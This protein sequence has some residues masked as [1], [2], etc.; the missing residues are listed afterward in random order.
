MDPIDIE[1]EWAEVIPILG[2]ITFS[3]F[4]GALIGLDREHAEKPAGIRTHTLMCGAACTLVMLSQ[5]LIQSFAVLEHA[6]VEGVMI[7]TDPVRVI[8]AIIT[9]VA[10]V[11]AG[12][13]IRHGGTNSVE[14][15][16]TAVG[17]IFTA[18]IGISVALG[19]W[20]I[21][22]ILTII[23]LLITSGFRMLLRFLLP[24]R[25]NSDT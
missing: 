23:V 22:V 21:A 16:T 18:A 12:T 5:R 14:G 10:F 8:E 7:R 2:P 1:F 17:L 9:G 4:L 24:N 11:G 3:M 13:I 6:P 15:L 25:T 20:V 19:E